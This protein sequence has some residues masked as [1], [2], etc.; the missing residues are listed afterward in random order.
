MNIDFYLVFY[1]FKAA[2]CELPV[3]SCNFK[4]KNLRIASSFSQALK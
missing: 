3:A 1:N 2:V 4:K